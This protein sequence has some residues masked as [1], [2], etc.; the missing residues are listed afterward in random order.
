MHAYDESAYILRCSSF[1]C[2]LSLCKC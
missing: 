2:L 1:S